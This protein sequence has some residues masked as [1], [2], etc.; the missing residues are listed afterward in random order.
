MLKPIDDLIECLKSS[1]PYGQ[2]E[3]LKLWEALKRLNN[4]ILEFS[5]GITSGVSS[6]GG[7]PASHIGTIDQLVIGGTCPI[8]YDPSYYGALAVREY[9]TVFDQITC[10]QIL[11]LFVDKGPLNRIRIFS[12][13]VG[14]VALLPF[15]IE[16]GDQPTTP[17]LYID[18]NSR[19]SL[20][21]LTPTALLHLKAGVAVVNGAPFKFTA[22]V[23]LTV[24]EI[25]AIEFTDDGTTASLFA[26]IRI[27]TIVTRVG[28]TP[29]FIDSAPL[30]KG[31]VDFTK[32][33]RFEVDG[34]TTGITRILTPLN[35][36]YTIEETGHALKH[37]NGG[38]DEIDV[39][40]LSGLL[41]D[42]Q[43]PLAHQITHN[44]G[45]S[46]P[47]KLDDLAIPDDN[48]DLDS[49]TLRHGL[50]RKLDGLT[51]TFLRGD[52]AWAAPPGGAGSVSFGTAILDFGAF[53]GKSDASV[54][55]TGQ[56]AIVAGSVVNAWLRPVDTVDHTT[57]EHMV[58]TLK[59][60][61]ANIIAGTGFTIYG[62]NTNQLSEPI[63]RKPH[64][65]SLFQAGTTVIQKISDPGIIEQE[66][67]GKIPMIYGQWT[68][69]WSWG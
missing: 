15:S 29:P 17:A 6:G 7:G 9:M 31:S 2:N 4:A 62:F 47:L 10:R 13:N 23:L 46:D 41:A 53:P 22:G 65:N 38:S 45:G 26:T 57:D 66:I 64:P 51:T 8:T 42:G 32:L 11:G 52:G 54:A 21:F 36:D 55:V 19:I 30:I 48:T 16:I 25:G 3:A 50:L 49:S 14:A 35:K 18:L 40:G 60:F 67:G 27:G 68:M 34:F 59:I 43:I 56:A 20:G 63:V 39:A 58:E 5:S 44:N 37:Q 28:I 69:A 1:K 12:G 61:A 24:P 33:L